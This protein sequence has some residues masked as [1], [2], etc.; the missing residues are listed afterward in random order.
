ME[1]KICLNYDEFVSASPK[2]V[3]ISDYE[4]LSLCLSEN[5]SVCFMADSHDV[6]YSVQIPL[7]ESKDIDIGALLLHDVQLE[8]PVMSLSIFNKSSLVVAGT[9]RDSAYLL[10]FEITKDPLKSLRFSYALTE[11]AEVYLSICCSNGTIFCGSADNSIALWQAN[12]SMA[13]QKRGVISEEDDLMGEARERCISVLSKLERLELIE[14]IKSTLVENSVN[15][16]P[17]VVEQVDFPNRGLKRDY[18]FV[19]LILIL[20]VMVIS[21]FSYM[22][23]QLKYVLPFSFK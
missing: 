2:S 5:Y 23:Y 13:Q 20:I 14:E 19:Y 11:H 4:L 10:F 17:I 6:V 22:Y 7:K 15:E 1:W 8:G 18:T 9:N 16:Q 3:Q 21:F 12:P